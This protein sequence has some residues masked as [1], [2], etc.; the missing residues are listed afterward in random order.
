MKIEFILE[1]KSTADLDIRETLINIKFSN[2]RSFSEILT[3]IRAIKG[4]TVINIVRPS[5][6]VSGSDI[7]ND[8]TK[9]FFATIKIKIEIKNLGVKNY[10]KFLHTSI[11]GINGVLSVQI[12]KKIMPKI[13]TNKA[14][15]IKNLL[16]I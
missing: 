12:K 5:R 15:E 16:T 10:I 9:T 1:E 6:M 3:E 14:Q 2:E 7:D 13:D 11:I 8:K 4:V